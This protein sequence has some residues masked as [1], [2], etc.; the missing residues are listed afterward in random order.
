MSPGAVLIAEGHMLR[1]GR[2]VIHVEGTLALAAGTPVARGSICFVL[3][4]RA[5]P[6][7]DH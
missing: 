4:P 6:G 2:A 7:R 5:K 3:L 1:R